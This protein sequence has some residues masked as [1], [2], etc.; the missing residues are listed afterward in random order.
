MVVLAKGEALAFVVAPMAVVVEDDDEDERGW[1]SVED[2][3][4]GKGDDTFRS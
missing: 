1:E 2:L 3:D 4:C